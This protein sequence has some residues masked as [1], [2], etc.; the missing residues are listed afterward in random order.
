MKALTLWRPWGNAILRWGK[1]IEN[2]TWSPPADIIDQGLPIAIHNGKQ[3]DG[4]GAGAI[5]VALKGERSAFGMDAYELLG[6]AG[7]V[8]GVV[9]V[10]GVCRESKSKWFAGPVGWCLA[11]PIALPTPVR[12]RGAQGLWDLPAD[13][14]REVLEQLEDMKGDQ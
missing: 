5:M 14:E 13:I 3:I 7:Y 1:D 9:C 8:I 11:D 6:P 2:R 10:T 12:C 4:E